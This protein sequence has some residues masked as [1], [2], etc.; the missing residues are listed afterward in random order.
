MRASCPK[1]ID[2]LN[3]ASELEEYKKMEPFNIESEY[4]FLPSHVIGMEII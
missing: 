1:Y 4:K 2:W 3:I